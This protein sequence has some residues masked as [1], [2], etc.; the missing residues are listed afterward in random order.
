[1]KAAR[2]QKK[3]GQSEVEMK[4]AMRGGG[5]GDGEVEDRFGGIFDWTEGGA[6]ESWQRW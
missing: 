5:V 2:S 6:V 4:S 3:W 1:M